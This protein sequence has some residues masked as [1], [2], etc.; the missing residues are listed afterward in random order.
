MQTAKD[1]LLEALRDLSHLPEGRAEMPS[2]CS[3]IPPNTQRA[4]QTII[5][6]G[7]AKESTLQRCRS[8]PGISQPN[9]E[10]HQR[11]TG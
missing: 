2:Y 10:C 11:T 4:E 7:P 9:A 6:N 5:Q 8:G 3:D 1:T